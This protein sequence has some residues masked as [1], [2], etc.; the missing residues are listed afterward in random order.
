MQGWPTQ[1]TSGTWALSV[2]HITKSLY[3]FENHLTNNRESTASVYGLLDFFASPYTGCP[4][5]SHAAVGT[6]RVVTP[7]PFD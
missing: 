2:W 6:L 7:T 1:G 3:I 4:Q 5:V